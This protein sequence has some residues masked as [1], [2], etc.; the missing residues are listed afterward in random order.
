MASSIITKNETRFSD[1]L[2][3]SEISTIMSRFRA[4]IYLLIVRAIT[5]VLWVSLLLCKID[6]SLGMELTFAA[7]IFISDTLDG[8]ISRRYASGIQ[9]FWFRVLD[10]LV[11]KVG[12]FI[13]LVALLALGHIALSVVL[14][15]IVYNTIIV[16]P[17]IIKLLGKYEKDLPWIQ[18]TFSSRFYAF[19]VGMFC[20]LS[21][22]VD[23]NIQ[24]NQI[25]FIYFLFLGIFSLSSHWV[26]IKKIK[27][28]M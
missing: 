27:E 24:Y 6:V 23:M 18:A 21:L 13:F 17:P 4:D 5:I 19:S 15:I 25:C 16:V 14:C 20:L 28:V 9:K 1:S 11:D 10:A 8:I 7:I 26:K 3:R 22:N 2:K 12:M